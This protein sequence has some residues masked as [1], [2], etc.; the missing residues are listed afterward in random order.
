MLGDDQTDRLGSGH[1]KVRSAISTDKRPDS[2]FFA[3]AGSVRAARKAGL[4]RRLPVRGFGSQYRQTR[5]GVPGLGAGQQGRGRLLLGLLLATMPALASAHGDPAAVVQVVAADTDGPR[6]IRLT[7]GLAIKLGGE[8]TYVCPNLFGLGSIFLA[9]SAD[10]ERTWVVGAD[11]LMTLEAD[12]TVAA[13]GEP[14]L[15]SDSVLALAASERDVYALRFAARGTEVFR[16][17]ASGSERIAQVRERF[18]TMA[19]AGSGA[20]YLARAEDDR[21]HVLFLSDSGE[22][23]SREVFD[24]DLAGAVP[25]LRVASEKLF[26]QVVR[27][28]GFELFHLERNE[29]GADRKGDAQ[30][31]FA[32]S[33]R[34]Y[35]PIAGPDGTTWASVDPVL[36]SLGSDLTLEPHEAPAS[37]TCVDSRGG[38]A[39]ACAQA[40]LYELEPGGLGKR[41][42]ALESLSPPPRAHPALVGSERCGHEWTL[43]SK[44]LASIGVRKLGSSKEPSADGGVVAQQDAGDSPHT[45]HGA[46]CAIGPP[47][48]A[49]SAWK[50]L[51]AWLLLSWMVRKVRV[52]LVRCG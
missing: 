27:P 46:C 5:H 32:G 31:L 12:G 43:F 23:T 1:K 48:L 19:V 34:I 13:R 42:M 8:W 4:G 35:G 25:R 52:G 17:A 28:A 15:A 22:E 51:G 30:S 33:E 50:A 44:D 47:S 36:Y 7:E 11:D 39:F 24:L 6:V 38:R 29:T 49:S 26:V 45:P 18:A 9:L 41:V 2:G 40:S 37:V 10:G 14:H 16:L 21:L 3:I 20:L